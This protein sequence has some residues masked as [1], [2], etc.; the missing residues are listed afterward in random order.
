MAENRRRTIGA[1]SEKVTV[2]ISGMTCDHCVRAVT[3]ELSALPSVTAVDV[4]LDSGRATI[5][6]SEHLSM[7]DIAAAVDEAGYTLS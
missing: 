2:S 7:T 3:A 1:M 6:S 5:E 4:D